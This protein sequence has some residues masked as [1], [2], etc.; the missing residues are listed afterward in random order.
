M[1]NMGLAT[2]AP[3]GLA[4]DKQILCLGTANKKSLDETARIESNRGGTGRERERERE[5]GGKAA[6]EVWPRR[7][8]HSAHEDLQDA[9]ALTSRL[10]SPQ[11]GCCKA[12][13]SPVL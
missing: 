2:A 12:G 3:S 7:Q 9:Q 10:L 11:E 8:L 6:L 5:T 13:K 4:Q 1:Q